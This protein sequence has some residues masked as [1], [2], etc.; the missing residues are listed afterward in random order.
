[1]QIYVDQQQPTAPDI[2]ERII[3]MSQEGLSVPE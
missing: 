2:T 1:M 3:T